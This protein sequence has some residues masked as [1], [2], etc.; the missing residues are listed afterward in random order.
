MSFSWKVADREEDTLSCTLVHGDDQ[1]QV[2]NC[3][4]VTNTFHTFGEPGGYAVVLE[5]KDGVNG[6]AKSVPVRVL[7]P[8]IK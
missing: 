4:E 1:Q 2:E 7:E 8:E 3:G 6:A 5:V